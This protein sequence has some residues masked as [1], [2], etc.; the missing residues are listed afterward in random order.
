MKTHLQGI[1]ALELQAHIWPALSD[2][3]RYKLGRRSAVR[4]GFYFYRNDRLIQAGGWNE[5]VQDETE[6]HSSLARVC[7][8]LPV[9]Y[10]DWFGINVQK[11]SVLVPPAFREISQAISEDGL[12][13]E[14][15]RRE[16]IRT[17]RHANRGVRVIAP[18][19][20][21]GLP[22]PVLRAI[23]SLHKGDIVEDGFSVVW[24]GLP[25][26]EFFRLEKSER[27]LVVNSR[28]RF[29]NG[30][31]HSSDVL[32]LLL[33][34]MLKNDFSAKRS[35]RREQEIEGLNSMLVSMAS[36]EAH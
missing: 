32:K 8:D 2:S 10:D 35:R 28:Y 20:T 11:S 36:G 15:Y 14:D 12:T 17:Y 21:A 19:A 18:I 5:L 1:G 9:A 23:K 4:Q 22:A 13:F 34:M 24:R 33:A 30:R 29:T 7:I 31:S 26:E 3:P 27:R 6:P 16:A 25:P